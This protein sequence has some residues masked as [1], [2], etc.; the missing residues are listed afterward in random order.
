MTTFVYYLSTLS[1]IASK[2]PNEKHR[3]LQQRPSL[4]PIAVAISRDFAPSLIKNDSENQ[5]TRRIR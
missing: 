3:Y 1:N 5:E 4:P 2:I